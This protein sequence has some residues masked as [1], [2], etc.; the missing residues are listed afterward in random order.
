[1]CAI[2]KFLVLLV[3]WTLYGCLVEPYDKLSLLPLQQI[4]CALRIVVNTYIRVQ[5]AVNSKK[6]ALE[7]IV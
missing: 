4:F 1:M 6:Y 3:N 7:I 5:I 2:A